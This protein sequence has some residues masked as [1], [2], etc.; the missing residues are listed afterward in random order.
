VVRHKLRHVHGQPNPR[1]LA[2]AAVFFSDASYRHGD[3]YVTRHNSARFG[4]VVW[5]AR[6]GYLMKGRALPLFAISFATDG[7]R[8]VEEIEKSPRSHQV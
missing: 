3:A 6:E 4:V 8:G 1:T 7:G 5:R 2:S